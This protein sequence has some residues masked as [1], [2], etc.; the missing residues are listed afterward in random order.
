MGSSRPYWCRN[1]ETWNACVWNSIL[2]FPCG[3]KR[4]QVEQKAKIMRS[5]NGLEL[6]SQ[7]CE[8]E[9]LVSP[10]DLNNS[11]RSLKDKGLEME[12]DMYVSEILYSIFPCGPYTKFEIEKVQKVLRSDNE[13]PQRSRTE[14]SNVRV[15][16]SQL[17]FPSWPQTRFRIEN[18]KT[19]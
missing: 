10:V 15:C 13:K 18:E 11:M 16:M 19:Q 17:S 6:E 14:A 9:I 5:H 7:M 2:W 3:L 8:S 4:C 1:E 12:P